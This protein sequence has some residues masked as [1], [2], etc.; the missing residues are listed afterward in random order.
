[1]THRN[2]NKKRIMK[3]SRNFI[4]LLAVALVCIVAVIP[5][6]AV[7]EQ[8]T[9]KVGETKRL[10]L[11]HYITSKAIKGSAWT[12]THPFGVAVMSQTPYSA[13]V[14][15]NKTVTE[16]CVIHCEYYYYV[17]A[18]VGKGYYDFQINVEA[19]K[20]TKVTLPAA[21]IHLNVGESRILTPTLTPSNAETTFTWYSNNASTVGVFQNGRIEARKEGTA[22]IT[23]KTANGLSA[24]CFVSCKSTIPD[25]IIT[26]K[27]DLSNIPAKANVKYERTLYKGWNS[28]CVPFA[29]NQTILD[30]A[31]EGGKIAV[32]KDFETI[33]DKEYL[34]IE[35]VKQIDAGVPC[36]VY[37]PSDVPCDFILKEVPLVN[38]PDDSTPLKG[39]FVKK[40]IGQG[41][42]KLALD[43]TSFG[44]T[45]TE[46]A[47][48][49]PFRAFIKLE[50]AGKGGARCFSV[51]MI[52]Q[53]K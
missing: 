20:P 53:E 1:M 10:Q 8:V 12:S 33:G 16:K 41:C 5:A 11:P 42:Y 9:I 6:Y 13:I 31:I 35:F 49:I 22:M 40:E 52:D 30:Q 36:L 37:V 47:T 45:K 39:S 21:E 23:V 28:L 26:D 44:Q 29:F 19:I 34:A 51:K 2:N 48:S 25:L 24:T 43:G 38:K 50:G 46:G 4:Y 18:G 32:Y 17:G 3:T 7:T 14:K 15:A 27:K